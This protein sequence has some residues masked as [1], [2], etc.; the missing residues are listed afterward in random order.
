TV[1]APSRLGLGATLSFEMTT[2][3]PRIGDDEVFTRYAVVDPMDPRLDPTAVTGVTLDGAD[4]DTAYYEVVRDRNVL[5]VLFTQAGLGWL[6]DQG[7]SDVV[8]VFEGTVAGLASPGFGL[9]DGVI[10]NRAYLL[11]D[12]ATGTVP[13][14]TPEV[15]P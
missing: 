13:P 8:V 14:T 10:T 12:H 7:G 6:K 11:A 5:M 4:V 15:P 1:G 9:P 3:V 2:G